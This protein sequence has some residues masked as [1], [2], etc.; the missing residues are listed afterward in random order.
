MTMLCMPFKLLYFQAPVASIREKLKAEVWRF[1]HQE[2]LPR[3]RL[4]EVIDIRMQEFEDK[5]YE[6]F[7]SGGGPDSAKISWT[8]WN[9]VV[10]CFTVFTTIGKTTT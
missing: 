2:N 1:T 5:L 8:F 4:D 3:K 10:Y 9:A 6:R 7:A